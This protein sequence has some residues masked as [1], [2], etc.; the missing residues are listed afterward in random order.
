MDAAYLEDLF[1]PFGPIAVKR[2]FGG[3]G[4]FHEG[5]MIALVADDRLYLKADAEA[6]PAFAAAGGEPFV[7]H[8]KGKPMEMGYWTVPDTA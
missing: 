2:M 1:A 8:G 7:Y 4:V 3:Q 5:L 6:R